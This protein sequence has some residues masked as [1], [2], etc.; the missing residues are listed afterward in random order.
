MIHKVKRSPED[1]SPLVGCRGGA[2]A[3]LGYSDQQIFKAIKSEDA[4]EGAK[5][6]CDD[7]GDDDFAEHLEVEGLE[8]AV[9][10]DAEDGADEGMGGGDGEAEFRGEEDGDSGAEFGG[11]TAGWGELGDFFPDGLDDSPAP[12]GKTDDDPSSAEDEEPRWDGGVRRE[13]VCF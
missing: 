3:C 5:G 13:G 8:A 6:D 1:A 12:G 2:L 10:S 4:E 11:K 7:P 9:E